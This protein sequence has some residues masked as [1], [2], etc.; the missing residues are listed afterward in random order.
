MSK[1]PRIEDG[2]SREKTRPGA[3]NKRLTLQTR[4]ILGKH[5]ANKYQTKR[6]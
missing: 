6:G 3:E 1:P 4:K 2:K 5:Y